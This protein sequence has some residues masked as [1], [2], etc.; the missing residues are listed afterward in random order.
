MKNKRNLFIALGLVVVAG[1]AIFLYVRSTASTNSIYQTTPAEKGNLQATVGATGTVRARQSALLTW[2]TTGTVEDVRVQVGDSV[3]ANQALATL[4]ETSLP[5]TIILAK[6]DLLSAQRGL[7]DLKDSSTARAQAE[8]SLAQ[9]EDALEEAQ[10][11]MDSLSYPRASDDL[12]ERTSAEIDLAKKQLAIADNAYRALKNRPDGDAQKAQALLNLTNAR[13]NLDNLIARYNW[14]TANPDSLETA[15]IKANYELAQAQY[16]DA[17]RNLERLMAGPDQVQLARLEAQITAAQATLD[18][19][20]VTA[21]FDGTITQADPLPGDLV[22]PSIPAFRLDDLTHLLVDV[23]ISEIDINSITPGQ[24]VA[25]SF[26]AIPDRKYTGKITEVGQTGSIVQGAVTFTITVELTDKDER[27]KPGMTAAVDILVREVTDVLLVPNRAVRVVDGQ[28]VVYIL[29]DGIPVPV[30]I[31]LGA[32]SD[33][34]SEVIDGELKEG[35]LIVLNPPAQTG[36][37]MGR[38]GGGN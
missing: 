27:V 5:Q 3:T 19:A 6:S 31:R 2:Q 1:I 16:A 4:Q 12:V 21:P 18:L 20:Q 11:K 38:P 9:A 10:K 14:Y 35:D 7:E 37:P 33:T 32:T 36:G 34:F 26:D 24:E 13:L 22:A 30:K 29:Q 8:V 28:R 17:K 15:Q 25:L 23:E